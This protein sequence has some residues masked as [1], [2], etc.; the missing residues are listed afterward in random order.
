MFSKNKRL[1][2]LSK[3]KRT[4]FG[5]KRFQK[6]KNRLFAQRLICSGLTV[7]ISNIWSQGGVCVC[8][9]VCITKCLAPC[10]SQHLFFSLS[11]FPSLHHTPKKS[12]EY[13]LCQRVKPVGAPGS[14]F[15][16][17]KDYMDALKVLPSCL[18]TA[19]C[20]RLPLRRVCC[21][22]CSYLWF[23]KDEDARAIVKSLV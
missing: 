1:L 18:P 6:N 14:P 9:R 15:T 11:P 22:I 12:A 2:F 21:A 13:C 3:N 23:G 17:E 8:K 19:F 10:L 16:E 7:D 4:V 20:V 5:A